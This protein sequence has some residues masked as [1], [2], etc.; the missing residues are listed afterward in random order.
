MSAPAPR[1]GDPQRRA[2]WLKTLHQWHWISS[3]LCLIGML[4]FSVTGITLNHASQIGAEPQVQTRTAQLPP[5]MLETLAASAQ[6]IEGNAPLPP[7]LRDWIAQEID[8]HVGAREGEWSSDEIYIALPRPGGDGWMAIDLASGAIESE[9][10]DRGWISYFNDLHK[11]RNAG[12]AWTWFI[13]LF[14]V[15]CLVFCLTGLFL[16]QMHARQRSM[17]WPMVGAGLLAPLLL[18]LL[19]VH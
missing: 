3:A 11:G 9:E 1:S 10:T 2:Y 15:A 8:V 7:D 17:T 6:Q 5:A 4:V 13:D 16:L 12:A 19:L 18:A 14:A